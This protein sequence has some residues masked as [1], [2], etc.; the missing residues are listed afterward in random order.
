MG[1]ADENEMNVSHDFI[2]LSENKK[3]IKEKVTSEVKESLPLEEPPLL[4]ENTAESLISKDK[5]D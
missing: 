3:K 2:P 5:L 1:I 4:K